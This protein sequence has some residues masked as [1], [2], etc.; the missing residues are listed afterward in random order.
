MKHLSSNSS[1]S[2]ALPKNNVFCQ[3]C[4][5][6]KHSRFPIYL[7]NYVCS[8]P[9]HS[10]HSD[11]WTFPISSFVGLKYYILFLDHFTHYLWVFLPKNK[12]KAFHNFFFILRILSKLNLGEISNNYSVITVGNIIINL[13]KSI[14]LLMTSFSDSG[15]PISLNKTRGQIA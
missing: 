15:V 1:I 9:L 12:S 6:G 13:F 8:A 10:V 14:S 4:R 3:I 5:I 2:C 11:L 7:S